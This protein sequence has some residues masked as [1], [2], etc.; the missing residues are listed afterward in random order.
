MK[1]KVSGFLGALV[2]FGLYFSILTLTSSLAGAW[3]QF[4][5][6]WYFIVILLA[7]FGVQLSLFLFVRKASRIENSQK[8][9]SAAIVTSGGISTGS[10]IA[11]CSHYLASIIPLFGLSAAAVFFTKY[12][13]AFLL[14]GV[15]ANITGLTIMLRIIQKH[16][17]FR[18]GSSL[19]GAILKLDMQKA[20]KVAV[21]ASVAILL[22]TF[23]LTA[24]RS[25][26]AGGIP[27]S[28]ITSRGGS[29]TVAAGSENFSPNSPEFSISMNT[30][31]VDLGFDMK[32]LSLLFD[33][34][35][36][37]YK[38]LRWEGSGPGGHH[39]TGKL[40]FTPLEGSPKKIKLIIR[41]VAGVKERA[42][43]W[44][45]R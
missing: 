29:V 5:Q 8:P 40:T 3:E 45:L 4:V 13:V 12:Q 10:M 30:H 19:F 28:T 34:R 9:S 7:G 21:A 14:L 24:A 15:L 2:L 26:G 22:V 43:E 11:C 6:V 35:G 39:R 23:L 1:E 36:K 37:V 25:E 18:G 16:Y 33:D 27:L 17:L 41:D 38:P 44:E 42:F 20:F 32:E 31:S